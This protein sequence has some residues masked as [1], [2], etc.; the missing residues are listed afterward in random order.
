MP[1]NKMRCLVVFIALV[2]VISFV[3]SSSVAPSQIDWDNFHEQIGQWQENV[4]AS[5]ALLN[6]KNLFQ[7]PNSQD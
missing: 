1:K 6:S 5:F 4:Q 7:P 2:A 3:T